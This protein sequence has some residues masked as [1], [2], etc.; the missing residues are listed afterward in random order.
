MTIHKFKFP[1]S[2][3]YADVVRQL[4]VL[5]TDVVTVYKNSTNLGPNAV[6]RF[7][8]LQRQVLLL[9]LSSIGLWAVV[10]ML[11]VLVL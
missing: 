11:A 4:D 3:R 1:R 9:T 8:S 7:R 10:A 2:D 6:A 5:K